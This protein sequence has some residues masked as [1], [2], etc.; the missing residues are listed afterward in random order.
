LAAAG[1]IQMIDNTP[2]K[3]PKPRRPQASRAEKERLIRLTDALL[4]AGTHR[5]DVYNVLKT[6]YDMS[7]RQATRYI[8]WATKQILARTNLPEDL[9]RADSLAFY[10]S[11]IQDQKATIREKILARNSIDR[12]LGLP[13]PQR[14]AVS[15][16][17]SVDK[18]M[19]EWT[20]RRQKLVADPEAAE[21]LCQL[22]ERAGGII[23][24][25]SQNGLK[26][27]R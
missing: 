23:A 2:K 8:A 12:L 5:W 7:K 17:R 14:I 24:D 13:K 6:E 19:A 21:L 26:T 10:Q 3:T 15:D 20:L 18:S 1:N 25:A 4:S 9:H 27:E 16:D 22:S 11:V